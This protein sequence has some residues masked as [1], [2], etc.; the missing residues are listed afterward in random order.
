M[1]GYGSNCDGTHVTSP[2]ADGMADAMRLALDDAGIDAGD[3]GY[4]NAHATATE[5]GDVAEAEA[6]RRVFGKAFR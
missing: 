6:T 4:V 3:V 5:V 1:I 2:S